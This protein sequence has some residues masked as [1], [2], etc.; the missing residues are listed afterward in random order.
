ML[1][2]TIPAT[3]EFDEAKGEFIY[4][5]EQTLQL[6]HSLLSISKWESKWCKPFLSKH[7]K[8]P[9]EVIDYIKCMTLNPSVDESVY[10]CLSQSNLNKINDY[11]GSPM[12]ATYFSEDKNSKSNREI[13]TSELIYY[14]MIALQIPFDP[15]QKWHLNRLLT[16]IRVCNIKNA[17]PKKMSKRDI[18]SRNA[19]LNAARRKQLNTKG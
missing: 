7:D 14:W 5:K 2:I 13:I 6:E 16:L 12:S 10:R 1:T 8:T 3:E 17:P 19:S 4:A 11:I 9:E 15:C 18:M